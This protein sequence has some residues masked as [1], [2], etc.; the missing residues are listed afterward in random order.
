M[1]KSFY[2]E[3]H[4]VLSFL[5]IMQHA[6]L[7]NFERVQVHI[8]QLHESYFPSCPSLFANFIPKLFFIVCKR[9]PSMFSSLYRSY[10]N[11]CG[12]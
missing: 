10:F 7:I 3:K 11:T 9:Y 12:V 1:T 4:S 6:S 5:F 8:Y 2:D